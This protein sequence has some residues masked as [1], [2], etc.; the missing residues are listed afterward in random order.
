MLSRIANRTQ[1]ERAIANYAIPVNVDD[2]AWFPGSPHSA[3][4][5]S[6]CFSVGFG[7]FPRPRKS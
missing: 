3:E 1:C 5:P 6:T 2:D 4:P 7:G